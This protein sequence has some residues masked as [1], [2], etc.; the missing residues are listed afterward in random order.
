MNKSKKIN[1]DEFL[2]RVNVRLRNSAA[3]DTAVRCRNGYSV[4]DVCSAIFEEIK[5]IVLDGDRLSITG[6]GSFYSQ[7]HKGHPVQFGRKTDKV[8]DYRV[9][10]F[11]ASNVLNRALRGQESAD[12]DAQ[13][14]D[15]RD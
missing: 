9:F 10:K 12:G 7:T 2:E 11:S 13:T 1:K 5:A 6:F 14:E 3:E 8:H 4:E 15:E